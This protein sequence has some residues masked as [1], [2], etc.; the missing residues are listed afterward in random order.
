MI[1]IDPTATTPVGFAALGDAAGTEQLLAQLQLGALRP[2]PEVI[3]GR[4]A[5]IGFLGVALT[6]I[7]TG[8][9]AWAQIFSGDFFTFAFLMAAVSAASVA[10]LLTCVT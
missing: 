4:A 7:G 5:M 9:S 1:R 3:N 8:R 6:E 2:G 10:P